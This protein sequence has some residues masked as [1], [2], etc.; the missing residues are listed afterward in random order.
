MLSGEL[1][2]SGVAKKHIGPTIRYRIDS[3]ERESLL[4]EA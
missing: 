2:V 4:N 3:S 1:E